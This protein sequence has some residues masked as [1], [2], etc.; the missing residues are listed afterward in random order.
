VAGATKTMITQLGRYAITG[1]ASNTL[2]YGLYLALTGMGAR[3][4]VAMSLLYAVG[5]SQTFIVNRA[6]SFRCAGAAPSAL[7]RY[8]A[9]YALGYLTNMAILVLFADALGW[10]HRYVQASA[11]LLVATLL[12]F[13]QRHWVFGST[14]AA[15]AS[16]I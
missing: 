11:I 3:P 14:G 4:E 2:L 5:V 12:F 16:A 15:G 13:L 6:W 9:C 8:I 1:V 7:L 10:D